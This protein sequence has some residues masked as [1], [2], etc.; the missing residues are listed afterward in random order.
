MEYD[1]QP[2]GME[3][4][5]KQITFGDVVWSTRV[6]GHLAQGQRRWNTR[7]IDI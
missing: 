3:Y 4:R 7:A 1:S 6:D 5:P 2:N